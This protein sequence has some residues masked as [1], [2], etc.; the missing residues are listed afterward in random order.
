MR[1]DDS[2]YSNVGYPT[3]NKIELT[4]DSRSSN[5]T[6][7]VG[8]LVTKKEFMIAAEKLAKELN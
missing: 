2:T 1:Q 8:H 3:D 6:L 7:S 5:F 4:Q